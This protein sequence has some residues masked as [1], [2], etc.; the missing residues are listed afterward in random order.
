MPGSGGQHQEQ[1]GFLS[2]PFFV[3]PLSNDPV[4][5][6]PGLS[7]RH[8]LFVCPVKGC[9]WKRIEQRTVK[10]VPGLFLQM[11][12]NVT[13]TTGANMAARTSWAAIGAAAHR[14][15]F[16]TTSGISVLVSIPGLTCLTLVS[17]VN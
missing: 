1:G 7:A 16:N 5:G 10:T 9:V 14:D 13:G 17:R 15:T 6:R 12:T 11:L 4:A 2:Q 3:P 8:A